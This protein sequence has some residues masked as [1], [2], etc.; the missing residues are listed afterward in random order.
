MKLIKN[1]LLFLIVIGCVEEIDVINYDNFNSLLVVE[2]TIT[3]Q[4]IT[5]EIRLSRA[6]PLNTEGPVNESNANVKIVGND[7]NLF[8][9]EE[10]EPGTYKSIIPFEA[11]SGVEYQLEIITENGLKYGS[12]SE[13]LSALSQL[14]DVYSERVYNEEGD[15][16]LAIFVDSY[17]SQGISRYYRYEYE[18]THKIIAPHY[19]DSIAVI[20]P[21]PLP[22]PGEDFPVPEITIEPRDEPVEVC[23]KTE[24][25]NSIIIASTIEFIEDRIDRFSVRFI[26]EDEYSKLLHRYS[27][28]VKQY[29]QS[30]EAHIYY[31]TLKEFSLSESLLYE[32]QAGFFEGNVFSVENI[33]E[34]VIGFFEV[35][36]VSSK[37]IYLTFDDYFSDLPSPRPEN[38]RCNQF[39]TPALT[40]NDSHDAVAAISPLETAIIG[41]LLYYEANDP[42]FDEFGDFAPFVLV[43]NECGDCTNFGVTQVPEWWED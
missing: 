36:S 31:K 28:L 23:Y 26:K 15:E 42:P 11:I 34:K 4:Y 25:A 37:R 6:Y 38:V 30:R 24:N 14:D 12:K 16:G 29:I 40:A 2:A 20:Q 8:I 43:L 17:D 33:N 22:E 41:G 9:F 13:S 18:E 19:N 3:N 7:G 1:I 5:Q 39:Y 32:N 10:N 21:Q 35:S 27:I